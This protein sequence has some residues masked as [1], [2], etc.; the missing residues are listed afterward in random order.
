MKTLPFYCDDFYYYL[1]SSSTAS[2]S[3]IQ[4][5]SNF[6]MELYVSDSKMSII[7]QSLEGF[8]IRPNG[9]LHFS[10]TTDLHFYVRNWFK[11]H[12]SAS[13]GVILISVVAPRPVQLTGHLL[14]G[15]TSFD[16]ETDLAVDIFVI[17]N[18]VTK[19]YL[20]VAGS[21]VTIENVDSNSIISIQLSD[22]AT[23]FKFKSDS[24][25]SLNL[26]S[27]GLITSLLSS[28]SGLSLLTVFECDADLSSVTLLS[29]AWSNCSSLSS[30]PFINSSNVISFTS[31]WFGCSGLL[32]FPSIPTHSGTSFNDSWRNCS[33][34]SSFPNL[35]L[36]AGSNLSFCW[37]GCLSL[38]CFSISLDFSSLT[39]G[40]NA[41]SGCAALLQPAPTG[42]SVRDGD[43]ALAGQWT[44][45]EVCG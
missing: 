3:F 22:N 26:A 14:P 36:S 6:E 42:S 30:F 10:P 5:T 40:A 25:V 24:W 44:N 23:Y 35:N 27:I 34:L 31:T 43:D 37:G 18:N 19:H 16:F 32:S 21:P 2:N 29:S 1:G 39:S 7:D 8:R 41:F 33:S 13:F 28:F 11:N 4:N 45:P 20:G 9:F 15:A 12:S 38:I 17:Q